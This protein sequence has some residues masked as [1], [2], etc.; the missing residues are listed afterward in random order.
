MLQLLLLGGGESRRVEFKGTDDGDVDVIG[1]FDWVIGDV[2]IGFMRGVNDNN[3]ILTWGGVNLFVLG[4]KIISLSHILGGE[5]D[6]ALN[7]FEPFVKPYKILFFISWCCLGW[8]LK[9][10]NG[11]GLLI[12]CC[13]IR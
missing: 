1:I 5:E 2:P 4:V 12:P 9:F 10:D 6:T 8:L 3:S 13:L 7:M 11:M